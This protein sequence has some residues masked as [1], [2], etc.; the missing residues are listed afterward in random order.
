MKYLSFFPWEEI[1]NISTDKLLLCFAFIIVLAVIF[2]IFF[3]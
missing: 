2:V 1:A 3:N